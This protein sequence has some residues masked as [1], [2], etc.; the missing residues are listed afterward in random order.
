ME[1]TVLVPRRAA[2][3]DAKE[4]NEP[5]ESKVRFPV[6]SFMEQRFLMG[7]VSVTEPFPHSLGLLQVFWIWGGA[8]KALFV[9]TISLASA[10]IP[11]GELEV[12]NQY[13]YLSICISIYIYHIY[14]SVYLSAT[15]STN[16]S[17]NSSSPVW[18]SGSGTIKEVYLYELEHKTKYITN[19]C[20]DASA[21]L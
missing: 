8:T 4:A 21:S 12:L 15:Q 6:H 7:G 9:K 11:M 14:T 5:K 3:Q 18:T 2:P 10:D 1:T 20:L 19:V 16:T 17:A 13:I